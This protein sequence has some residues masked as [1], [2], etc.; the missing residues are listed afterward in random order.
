VFLTTMPLSGNGKLH[1]AALPWPVEQIEAETA[2]RTALEDRIAGMWCEILGRLSIRAEDDFFQ[3]GG[4]SLL[5][6][7]VL[8]RLREAFG[9]DLP[10]RAIFDDPTVTG[11]ARHVLDALAATADQSVRSI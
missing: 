9:V 6:T 3:A 5:A 4:H 2:P 11:M 8:V 1:R 7:Q 10:L